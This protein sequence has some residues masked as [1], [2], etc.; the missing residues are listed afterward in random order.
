[1]NVMPQGGISHLPY[2]EAL[3]GESDEQSTS[4]REQAAGLLAL[5]LFD[6]WE[7]ARRRLA[8][9]PEPV[10]VLA[11]RGEIEALE[12][13]STVRAPLLAL[14][15]AMLA[16]PSAPAR[17]RSTMRSYATRLRADGRWR[18]AADVFRTL[19][20]TREPMDISAEAYESAMDCGYCARQG[21]D[22]EEA[23]IAYDVGE[24]IATAARDTF[25]VLRARVGKAK[26]TIHRGNLP[27]A[28]AELEAIARAAEAA[29]CHGALSL[30][31]TDR[32]AVAGMRGQYEQAALYGYRALECCEDGAAREMILADLATA[33]GDAGER[34][35]ARDAHLVLSATA[36]DRR[37]RGLST[38]N[39]LLMAAADGERAAFEDYRTQLDA[40]PL[41][42][43]LGARYA[44]ALGE[45]YE[46]FGELSEA[47]GAYERAVSMAE[48]SGPADVL[49]RAEAA[50]AA[51][52]LRAPASVGPAQ[53]QG[54]GRLSYD[55]ITMGTVT[56]G[57][58]EMRERIGRGA[59]LEVG[60]A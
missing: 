1:M 32:M 12:E 50:L 13:R 11:V 16:V 55:G 59:G 41:P 6:N 30:A 18:L 44:L 9:A 56:R 8:A 60:A 53:A 28:D 35:A 27:Q 34:V 49:M 14:V 23:G 29:Q 33:L 45:G 47:R 38:V 58:R 22:I 37:V 3:A 17:V 25:G 19:V 7:R 39:L 51:L 20:E 5:R 15:D 54:V 2:F 46:R 57:V 21:G 4:W 24:A 10:R 26:L 36:R 43:E 52:D 40:S 42:A 31:L 48:Q